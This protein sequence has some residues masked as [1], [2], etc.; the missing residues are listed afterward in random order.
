M[1]IQGLIP[2]LKKASSPCNVKDFKGAVVAIDSYCWL[3]K[4]AFAC[5]EKLALGEKT[6]QYVLYCMKYVNSLLAF[7]IKPIMVFDGCRLPSKKEVEQTRRDRRNANRKK[8][9]QLLREGKKAE[10][11]D[12]LVQCIDITPHMALELIKACRARGVD[13][14]VA[15][16]EAD[17]QLAYLNQIGLADVIITEDSDLILFGCDKILFKMDLMGNGLLVEKSKLHLAIDIPSD[18]FTFEKFQR[19]CIL[20]GCDYLPSLPGIGLAKATKVFKLSRQTDMKQVLKRLPMILKMPSLVVTDDYINN[21]FKAENTFLYQLVF[22]PLRR[23]LL[24]LNAYP[25]HVL[26]L[27]MSYAGPSMSDEEALQIALGNVNVNDGSTMAHYD[28]DDDKVLYFF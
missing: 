8:A 4:G 6:D 9:A 18:Q 10:A 15:P 25:A 2:F 19:I 11:R 1:G 14:I 3:H 16:Y 21:F 5:A 20:S 22:D 28:P 27:D 24:P 12:C 26:R 7:G 13:C 23:K 17:A